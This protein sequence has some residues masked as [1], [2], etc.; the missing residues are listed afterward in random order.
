MEQVVKLTAKFVIGFMDGAHVVYED[1][2]VVYKGS[3]VIYVGHAYDGTVD[4]V[5]DEGLAII[6]PGFVDLEADIDTDHALFDIAT[7]EDEA[8]RFVM[9][10]KFRT[11]QAFTAEDLRVRHQYSIAQLIKNGITTAMPISGETFYEWSHSYDEAVIMAGVGE[12]MGMR[13]YLGPSF[14]SRAAVDF[15]D[16]LVREA[17]S[18]AAAKQFCLEF[19]QDPNKLINSLVNPC[20]VQVT[21]LEVLQ[22]M[23]EFAKEHQLPYRLHAAEVVKEWQYLLP[24]YEQT[25][26]E[27]FASKGMLFDGCIIP[28]CA[29]TTNN[30]LQLLAKHEVSVV[31]TPFAE[32]NFGSALKSFSKYL[33]YGVNLTIGTD[34]QPTDMIR[35]MRMAWDTDRIFWQKE[36]VSHYT[37]LGEQ[38]PMLPAEPSYPK[39]TAASK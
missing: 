1:G 33:D 29:V 5:W 9:G 25:S 2:E 18:I 19:P 8:S 21:R 27:L 30:E 6:A 14:K 4:E 34:C 13:M 3:E 36:I 38:L 11:Q 20:Q 23:A 17:K 12:Q 37:E 22:E 35:N 16:D 26:I 32:A 31:V 15:P 39:T 24:R 28:H 7:P 10:P